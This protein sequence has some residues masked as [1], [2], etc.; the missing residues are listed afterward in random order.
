MEPLLDYYQLL[1]LNPDFEL[2]GLERVY[3]LLASRYHPDNPRTGD[4]EKFRRVNQAYETLSQPASRAAYDQALQSRNRFSLTVF[5]AKEFDNSIDGEA[6]RRLGLLCLLY[7]RR[8][9]NPESGGQS[10]LDLER[11]TG[12]PR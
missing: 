4:Q 10:I 2:E 7:A 5:E 3:H 11:S 1:Q 6:N 8:R 12:F 9:S